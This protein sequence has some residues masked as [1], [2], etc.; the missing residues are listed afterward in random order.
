MPA[1]FSAPIWLGFAALAMPLL[2]IATSA[3]NASEIYEIDDDPEADVATRQTILEDGT[4]AQTVGYSG[5]GAASVV[6]FFGPFGIA[7]NARPWAAIAVALGLV[8]TGTGLIGLLHFPTR[9]PLTNY[10]VSDSTFADE[11]S[12]PPEDAN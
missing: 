5:S 2:L 3:Y 1:F 4:V 11:P 7:A 12:D 9:V 10:S 6:T 8:L